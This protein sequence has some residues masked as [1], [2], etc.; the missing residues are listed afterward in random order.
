LVKYPVREYQLRTVRMKK[1]MRKR[2]EEEKVGGKA[3]EGMGGEGEQE[4]GA[5]YI[6]DT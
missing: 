1:I 6:R 2:K 3:E 5:V 4:R